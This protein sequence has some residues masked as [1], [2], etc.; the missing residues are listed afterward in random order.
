MLR[1][2]RDKGYSNIH[3]HECCAAF[4]NDLRALGFTVD[5]RPNAANYLRELKDHRFR[6]VLLIDV[7]EHMNIHEGLDFLGACFQSLSEGGRLILQ[8]PNAS[9]LFG[10]T[11]FT[12]DPTHL[13]LWNELR[14]KTAL[15][16]RGYTN[17]KILPMD[18]PP[19]LPNRMRKICRSMIFSLIRLTTRICGA[20][21]VSVLTHNVICVAEK[22]NLRTNSSSAPC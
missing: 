12:A 9:G 15:E 8:V 3:A 1:L 18:L 7:L 21:P 13:T 16:A 20:T 14:L 10:L 19:S 4:A 5:S 2:L 22:P 6:A 11:T 17:V